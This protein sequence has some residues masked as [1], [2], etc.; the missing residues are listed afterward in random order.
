MITYNTQSERITDQD[1]N[2]KMKRQEFGYLSLATLT[3][4][5]GHLL[6]PNISLKRS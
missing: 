3:L 6:S 1:G 5:S 4:N 2:L